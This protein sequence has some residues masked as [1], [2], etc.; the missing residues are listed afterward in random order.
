MSRDWLED[1]LPNWF[2]WFLLKVTETAATELQEVVEDRTEP[3]SLS[4][5][6][7]SRLVCFSQN[8]FKYYSLWMMDFY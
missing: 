3:V 1:W 7:T 5:F 8:S 4:L 6:L 2:L